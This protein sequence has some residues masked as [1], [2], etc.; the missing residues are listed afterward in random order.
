MKRSFDLKLSEIR[1]GI[2]VG[3]SFFLGVLAIMT[4]GKVNELFSKQVPLT[5]LFKNVR[6][7]T[8]GSPVR[9]SGI[10]SGFVKSV[11]FVQYQNERYVQV[12]IRITKKRLFELSSETTATIRTQG[13]MGIKYIE[14]VPG[15][16]SKGPLNI[17]LPITG[18]DTRTLETVLGSGNDL[19]KS[20]NHVSNSLD[21]L[22]LQA[23]E[24]KGTLGRM[25]TR[26]DLYDNLNETTKNL[27][28]LVRSMDSGKGPLPQMLHS[29]EMTEKLNTTLK[30]LNDLLESLN[31]PRG[32]LGMIAHDPKAAHDLSTSLEDL[33]TILGQIKKGK[34]TLG[35]ILYNPQMAQRMNDTIMKV[36]NLLDDMKKE[37]KKYFTVNVHIF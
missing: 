18:Q 31:D 37:P 24:G 20:L 3:I 21:F 9:I 32:T 19:V 17:G 6:G 34:G 12:I 5:L 35:E 27:R 16:L 36:N 25:L 8:V 13:L 11:H 33:S 28:D 2:I 26:P 14:L 4:Y 15:D 10:T 1:V 7:L 22:L 23:Q 29:P 30:N